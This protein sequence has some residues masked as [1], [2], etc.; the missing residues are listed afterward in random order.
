MA[1]HRKPDLQ[2]QIDRL[3]R[4]RHELKVQIE[5]LDSHAFLSSHEQLLLTELKKEKLAAKDALALLR[6]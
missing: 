1:R 3:E 2:F 5:E 4:K 6:H